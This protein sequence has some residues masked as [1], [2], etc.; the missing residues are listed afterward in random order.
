M[1][2]AISS[3]RAINLATNDVERLMTACMCG[4]YIIWTPLLSIGIFGIG[5]YII[6]WPFACGFV[7]LVFVIVP[8]QLSLSKKF[9]SMRAEIASITDEVSTVSAYELFVFSVL[10]FF[11]S[12]NSNL[13]VNPARHFGVSGYCWSKSSENVHLRVQL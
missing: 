3:G 13:D 5:W 2:Y 10:P 8:F 12:T 11:S 7:L 4:S 9:A 1:D 6:G